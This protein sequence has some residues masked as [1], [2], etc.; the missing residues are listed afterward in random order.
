[1]KVL[2]H[3]PEDPARFLAVR[4][5]YV[6]QQRWALPGGRYR[7]AREGPDAAARREVA[8]ELGL[9]IADALE[10]LT[11]LET[12]TEGKRDTLT[13]LA[14]T[15]AGTTVRTSWELG[16]ARWMRTDLGD[17]PEGDPVSRWVRLALAA[18]EE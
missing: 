1:V 14:G 13:I 15:A 6:D 9:Q 18:R 17:L 7:P 16:E 3:H 12:T 10:E 4:H 5:S 2:L 11:T 8:E